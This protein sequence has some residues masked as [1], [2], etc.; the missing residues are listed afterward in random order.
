[1]YERELSTGVEDVDVWSFT[2]DGTPLSSMGQAMEEALQEARDKARASLERR[3]AEI[4]RQRT[5]RELKKLEDEEAQREEIRLAHE[6]RLAVQVGAT[7][8]LASKHT[9]RPLLALRALPLFFQSSSLVLCD[10]RFPVD[11]LGC[12]I[13]L[14]WKNAIQLIDLIKMP[15]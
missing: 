15:I 1:M 9:M 4:E 2:G 11:E 13:F 12:L 6:D 3:R 10:V 7:H 5:L 14:F 8:D